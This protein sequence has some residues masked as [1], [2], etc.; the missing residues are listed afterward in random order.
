MLMLFN[1]LKVRKT[2]YVL[3]DPNK[4][5]LH[6][7]G[8]GGFGH[9]ILIFKRFIRL[10]R[11]NLLTSF[12]IHIDVKLFKTVVFINCIIL[13]QYIVYHSRYSN[14]TIRSL[15]YSDVETVADCFA[16]AAN[17]YDEAKF[18]IERGGLAVTDPAYKTIVKNH[19]L[20]LKVLMDERRS[21]QVKQFYQVSLMQK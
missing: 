5:I 10:D 8:A 15:Y 4:D 20:A 21:E 11:V 9:K 18:Q 3:F 17:Y 16:K 7:A 12:P 6:K 19:K 14:K 2:I 13:L 1:Q